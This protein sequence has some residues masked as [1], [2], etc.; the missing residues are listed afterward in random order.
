MRNDIQ[1]LIHELQHTHNP[2]AGKSRVQE[3]PGNVVT[4]RN[5]I[6]KERKQAGKTAH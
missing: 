4:Q 5:P 6:S 2:G 3:Q 1:N